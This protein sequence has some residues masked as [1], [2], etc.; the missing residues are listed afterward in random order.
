MSAKDPFEGIAPV[1]IAGDAEHK[2]MTVTWNDGHVSE[3]GY[4]W[5]RWHCPCAT[6]AGEGDVP[7]SLATTTELTPQ[8][9]TLE[10]LQLVGSYGMS[11]VWQDGHHTG[12]YTFRNLRMMC[13]CPVCQAKREELASS[14]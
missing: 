2:R 10:D 4:E 14:L 1:S 7:G 5:L 8:Q 3:L 12:I 9:T 13:P 11:P 6:C